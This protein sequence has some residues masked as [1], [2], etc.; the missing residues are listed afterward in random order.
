MIFEI[1]TRE[2]AGMIATAFIAEKYL[3]DQLF[4]KLIADD[5]DYDAEAET[6]IRAYGEAVSSLIFG[7]L[8]RIYKEQDEEW[9]EIMELSKH[10][11][12]MAITM[13]QIVIEKMS[14]DTEEGAAA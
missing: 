2:A 14:K 3:P 7:T 11:T 10:L 4:G 13:H 6:M 12:E 5:I 8:K 9:D 1:T